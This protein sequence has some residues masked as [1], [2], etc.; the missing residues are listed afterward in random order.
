MNFRPTTADIRAG[1]VLLALILLASAEAGVGQGIV[2]HGSQSFLSEEVVKKVD[3]SDIDNLSI[4]ASSYLFGNLTV[5]VGDVQQTE[6][7]YR[8]KFKADTQ[9][10]AKSFDDYIQLKFEQLENEFVISAETQ[11]APPWSGTNYSASLDIDVTTPR[12]ERLKIFV[13]TS[14]Y[15]IRVDGEY[16]VVDISSAFGDVSVSGIRNKININ[17]ENAAVLVRNC[18]GPTRVTTANRPIQLES[19][20]SQLGTIRL[21]NDNGRIKLINVRGEIDARTEYAEIDA[22]GISFEPGRSI[23]STANSPLTVSTDELSGDLL[24]RNENAHSTLILPENVSASLSLQVDESGRI[25]TKDLPIKVESVTRKQLRGG[26][27]SMQNSISVEMTGVGTIE[28]KG[29]K[30]NDKPKA[31]I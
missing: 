7:H 12:Y 5:H 19:V 30:S 2:K 10:Q 4:S 18:T 24:L 31:D 29:H 8:K 11:S 14:S 26:I 25:Y 28:L 6:I 13:R 17:C 23:L 3:L 15:D 21:R 1:V 9:E 22:E 16:A 20:D 27:G